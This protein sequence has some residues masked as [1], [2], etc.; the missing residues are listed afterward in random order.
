MAQRNIAA[1]FETEG[2]G[3]ALLSFDERGGLLTFSSDGELYLARRLDI[4]SGQLLDANENI[5]QQYIERVELE[6][7]RSMDYFDRQFH[8][9]TLGKMLVSAPQGA[10][11]V[12][13]FANSLGLPVEELNLAESFNLSAAPALL[14]N[15]FVIEALPAIGAALRQERR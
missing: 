3:L 15:D 1:L 2:R 12:Q 5:R 6:I 13:L 7:Q 4:T 8:Y 14:H 10:R 11:L 9:I